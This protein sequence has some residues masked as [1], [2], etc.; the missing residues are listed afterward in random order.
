MNR[1]ITCIII[2]DE[3][4]GISLVEEYLEDFAEFKVV[5]TCA[6]GFEGLKMIQALSPDLIF[7]DV[8]MPRITGIEMLELLN[9]PPHIIFTTA[10]EQFA[11][12]AFEAN[13]IDYLLKP[14]NKVRFEK[15]IQKY[16]LAAAMP[17]KN[18]SVAEPLTTEESKE[19]IVVKNGNAIQII[20][21]GEIY[22]L[23]ADDDY[24]KI[25]AASGVHLKTKTLSYFENLLPA[26]E[27]VRIH[28][29]YLVSIKEIKKIDL[30]QKGTYQVILHSGAKLPVSGS[31]YTRLRQVMNW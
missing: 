19:R 25:H 30:Y 14:F 17:A 6:D 21:R 5:A 28:R 29:S 7:L 20:P 12:Q 23:E 1:P 16:L 10:Y 26:Q 24:V 13:A 11:L 22:Y 18:E 15:A 27:F 4:L 2:D 9:N 3:P 8:Q 31:G